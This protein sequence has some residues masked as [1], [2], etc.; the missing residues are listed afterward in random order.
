MKSKEHAYPNVIGRNVPITTILDA[1]Y[2]NSS[3]F[4]A[5]YGRRRIGKTFLIKEIFNDCFSFS[6]TGIEEFSTRQQLG[7]FHRYL[8]RYGLPKCGKPHN[9]FDA[10]DM[11]RSL[12]ESKQAKAF[13]Y[14]KKIIFLDELPWM[15]AKG[16]DF[17]KALA[18]FWNDW[19]AWTK[20]IML[21]ICGSATSWMMK[22]VFSNRGGLYDRVTKQIYLKPFTLNE[23]E[24]FC[25]VHNIH[26]TRNLMIEAYMIIG[27]I[28]Y[29]WKMLD[30]N[31]SLNANIDALFFDNDAPMKLEHHILFKS[32]FSSPEKYESIINVL[33]NRKKGMT[34]KDISEA[35]DIGMSARLTDMIENLKLSGFIV[36]SVQPTKRKRGVIY[37][38]SDNFILFYHDFI[39]KRKGKSNFWSAHSQT[40][41]TNAWRGLAFERVCAQHIPQIQKALGI[42][43]VYCNYYSWIGHE[44]EE[45]P[46][47]QI[48][49]IIDR[50]DGIVNICE[51]KYTNGPFPISSDYL[52]ELKLRCIRYQKEVAPRKGVQLTIVAAYGITKNNQASEINSVVA[53]DDLFE[54]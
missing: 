38:L 22:K 50:A 41:I 14:A 9:W 21:I 17:V 35:C 15:D 37:Q 51:M 53:I 12:I 48:D 6:Y 45:Y 28:P 10:F 7:E 36:E 39:V 8:L 46:A 23:C 52:E 3:E 26:W 27:G 2:S 11:L 31:K 42:S 30:P 18:H 47:M 19:A 4:I 13:K 33:A 43:G 54:P 20:D 40:G 24:L 34:A 32:M 25:K 44:T 1:V 5:V 49:L 16:S 29:Y